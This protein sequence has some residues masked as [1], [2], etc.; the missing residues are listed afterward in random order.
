MMEKGISAWWSPR[1]T[2]LLVKTPGPTIGP[3]R[4]GVRVNGWVLL[5]QVPLGYEIWRL[6]N[7]FPPVVADQ[8][9]DAS[10]V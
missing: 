4:Q 3:L 9:P 1:T 8:E 2:R 5:K 6:L 10:K 7:G